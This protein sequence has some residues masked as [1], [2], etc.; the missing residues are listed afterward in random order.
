MNR[1]MDGK[2]DRQ[3]NEQTDGRKEMDRKMQR[4]TE[5]ELT[6]GRKDKQMYRR[7]DRWMER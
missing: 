2:M 7:M 3:K 6:D 4:W 5:D 1:Q